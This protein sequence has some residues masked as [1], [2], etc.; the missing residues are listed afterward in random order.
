MNHVLDEVTWSHKTRSTR[1]RI[2]LTKVVL[3]R[4]MSRGNSLSDELEIQFGAWCLS[5][6]KKIRLYGNL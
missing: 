1:D 3:K 5:S 6:A 4:N 2:N